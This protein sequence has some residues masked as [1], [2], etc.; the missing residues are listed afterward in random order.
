MKTDILAD[1]R[2]LRLLGMAQAW[3]ELTDP[4]NSLQFN[5]DFPFTHRS[6]GNQ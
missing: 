6:N 2:Q 1:L 3:T 4:G 5:P